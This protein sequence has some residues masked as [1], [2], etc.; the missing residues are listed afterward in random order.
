MRSSAVNFG[1]LAL[2]GAAFILS[3]SQVPVPA[4]YWA[5]A[6]ALLSGLLLSAMSYYAWSASSITYYLRL[7]TAFALLPEDDA[8]SR[9]KEEKPASTPV[10]Q[11]SGN[12][13]DS[14]NGA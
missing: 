14:A 2:P 8:P 12:G 1:F 13:H 10:R 6:T 11:R 7:Q 3:R 5:A 4:R 9:Q